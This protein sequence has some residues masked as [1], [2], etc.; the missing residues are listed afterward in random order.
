M[1][2]GAPTPVRRPL[3]DRAHVVE[4]LRR[5]PAAGRMVAGDHHLN[6]GMGID[7]ALTPAA[8]L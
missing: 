2:A 1:T 6:P 5:P 7:E 3:V 4:R 8:V